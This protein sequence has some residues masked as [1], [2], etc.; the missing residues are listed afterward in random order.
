MCS[1]TSSSYRAP[2]R[3]PYREYELVL[4][5]SR[6]RSAQ[7]DIGGAAFHYG[8]FHYEPAAEGARGNTLLYSIEILAKLSMYQS[9]NIQKC[10]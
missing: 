3:D 10:S 9:R 1:I 2:L 7:G 4:V 6:L 5:I 8:G